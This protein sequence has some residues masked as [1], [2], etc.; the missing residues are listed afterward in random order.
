MPFTSVEA[1]FVRAGYGD[2]VT[3]YPSEVVAIISN[4][5]VVFINCPVEGGAF[6]RRVKR[7]RAKIWLVCPRT[8]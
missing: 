2:D 5:L 4:L 8:D 1:V 3:A 7:P 6:S